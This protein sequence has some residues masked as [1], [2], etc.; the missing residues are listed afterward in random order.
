MGT[1]RPHTSA[2]AAEISSQPS[3]WRQ[4]AALAEGAP[5]PPSGQSVALIGCGTSLFMAQAVAAWREA[6]G[7]GLSDAFTPSE[8]PRGRTYDS[9][10]AISRSG[11]TTE[12]VRAMDSLAAPHKVAIT[13]TK[14]SP[15]GAVVDRLVMLPFADEKAVVQTRFAT[16]VVA[17]WRAWL[18]HDLEQLALEG[19]KKLV[20]DLPRSLTGF[21]QFVF[22]GHGPGVGLASEAGLKFREA[23]LAWSEAYPGM[24]LRHGP[25]SVLGPRSLVWSLTELPEGLAA[26]ITATGAQLETNNGDPLP[27]LVRIHRAAIALALAKRLDPDRPPHLERSV[28]LS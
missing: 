22:L 27:E 3:V 5:L 6:A 9:L 15:L 11:T 19:E 16:C 4:A 2:V 23:A 28:V 8:M 10:V 7:H 21:E 17:L 18:G 20:A 13:A 26:E 14:D 1:G 25:I 12:V 24:E